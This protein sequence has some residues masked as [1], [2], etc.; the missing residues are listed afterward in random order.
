M[1]WI[2]ICFSIF[3]TQLV[4]AQLVVENS[5]HNVLYRGYDNIIQLGSDTG[6]TSLTILGGPGITVTKKSKGRFSVRVIGEM[7]S[8]TLT[9]KS[10]LG[11]LFTQTYSVKNLPTPELYWGSASAGSTISDRSERNISVQYPYDVLLDATFKVLNYSVMATGH[12]KQF[13]GTGDQLTGE[14]VNWL[15]QLTDGTKVSFSV[16]YEGKDK[17]IRSISGSFTL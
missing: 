1:K 17:I 12:A 7:K 3:I 15:G 14:M 6:D 8:T 16:K 9:V 11:I 5:T 13:N 2:V 10:K 4:V